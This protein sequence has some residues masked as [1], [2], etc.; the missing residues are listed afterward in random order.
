M[1]APSRRMCANANGRSICPI[2]SVDFTEADAV[3]LPHTGTI[4]NF[5]IITPVQY[6]GQTETEP[7]AR[8]F[9]L[10][11]GTDVVVSY[12]ALIEMPVADVRVG[13]RVSAVWASP[14]EDTEGNPLGDLIGWMPNGEPAIDDPDLL[15]RIF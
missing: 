5:V 4:T 11:D 10:L 12:Q 3:D 7:F 15:N 13:A 2:D 14:G 6:P 8:A 9:V 1:S